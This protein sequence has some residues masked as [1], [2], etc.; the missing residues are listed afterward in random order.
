MTEFQLA[1]A[2][3]ITKSTNAQT[4]YNAYI[5]SNEVQDYELQKQVLMDTYWAGGSIAFVFLYLLVHLQSLLLACFSILMILFSFPVTQLIYKYVFGIS[6]FVSIHNLVVFIVL[7]IACDDIFVIVD[8][9]RQSEH[10]KEFK[11]SLRKRLAYSFR[12]TAK[13]VA[14]TSSTTCC[15]FVANAF[16]KILPIRAFGIYAAIIIPVNYILIYVML[17][18]MIVFH[19]KYFKNMRCCTAVDN[20]KLGKDGKMRVQKK[21]VNKYEVDLDE[22]G[23]NCVDGFFGGPWNTLVKCSRWLVLLCFLAWGGYTANIARKISPLTKEE[24]LFPDSHRIS[25]IKNIIT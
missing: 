12:K 23:P 17:P 10:I 19:D 21:A 18:P 2:N 3:L 1:V 24:Q 8:A 13:A 22:D 5:F 7:G 9:W 20:K 16:S 25:L 11:G 6:F 15:A 4:E 14:I